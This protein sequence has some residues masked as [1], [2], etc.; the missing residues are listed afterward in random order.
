LIK[1]EVITGQEKKN[2]AGGKYLFHLENADFQ[3]I[4]KKMY[5]AFVKCSMMLDIREA[6]T[7]SLLT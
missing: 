7:L 4:C 5:K 1:Y 3:T 2:S 6:Q